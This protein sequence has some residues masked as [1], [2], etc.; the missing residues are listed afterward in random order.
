M[1]VV[2]GGSVFY[3]QCYTFFGNKI[4]LNPQLDSPLFVAVLLLLQPVHF[5]GSRPG[6]PTLEFKPNSAT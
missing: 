4:Y 6:L 1:V 5:R 2:V 3:K